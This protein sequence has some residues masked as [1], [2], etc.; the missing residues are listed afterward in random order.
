MSHCCFRPA[1]GGLEEEEEEQ[2]EEDGVAHIAGQSCWSGDAGVC[3]VWR[4]VGWVYTQP[5]ASGVVL[6]V[7]ILLPCALFAYMLLYCP[8]L[9]IDLSYS[10]FEVH[11]DFSAERFDALTIAVKT[12]LG[13]WDRRRRDLDNS[14][15]EALRD[16]QLEKL[17]RPG[18]VEQDR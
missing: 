8:P 17:G 7:V 3:G 4:V 1:R 14:E 2:E 11:S 13:S 9:D 5:W 18:S 15:S 12:Q 6:G 16:L 10:A